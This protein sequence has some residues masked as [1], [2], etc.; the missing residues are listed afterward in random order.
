MAAS[1][2]PLTGLITR[3]DRKTG[4]SVFMRVKN[5]VDWIR[6]SILSLQGFADEIIV[7]D[8]GSQDGTVDL[9]KK[10]QE[11]TTTPLLLFEKPKLDI[12]TLSN[13][14]VAQTTFRWVVRWD[15]DFVAHTTGKNAISNLRQ[16]IFSL[17]PRCY[18]LIY[19]RLINL[20]GDLFH[21]NSMEMVHIEEYI[22][23]FSDQAHYIHP[24]RFEA[25]KTPI[26]YRVHF[27]YETYAFHVNV[28]SS[29]RML[30]RYFWEDW[31][32]LKDYK[33]YPRLEDYVK[34]HLPEAFGT[35]SLDEAEQ[36]CMLNAAQNYTPYR[37]DLFGPYPELL[38]AQLKEPKYQLLYDDN[39]ISGRHENVG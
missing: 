22:H 25:L 15:G 1:Y 6:P 3:P 23:T 32:E 31:M 14:A 7:V 16:R 19:L 11:I 10:L 21:Q 34:A 33:Q 4:I 12:N 18:H 26:Y 36:I 30:M 37:Q 28:K 29:R 39:R 17:D 38:Q 9:I 24:G 20:C 35:S 8:N 13:F 5:E 2:A 27:W